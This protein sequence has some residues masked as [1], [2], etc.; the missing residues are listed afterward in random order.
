MVI[1]LF[2]QSLLHSK[3]GTLSTGTWLHGFDR[4][5]ARYYVTIAEHGYT[6]HQPDARAFFPGYPLVVRAA[7]S[8][9][10]GLFSYEQTGCLVSF[11]AFVLATALLYRLVF[12]RFGLRAALV[13]SA[14]FCWFPT[15][16]FFLAPYSEAFFALEILTVA[17]LVDRRRWWWAAVVVGYASATSPEALVLVVAL[18]AAALAAHRG[19]WRSI[20]YGLVGS[21]GMAAYV[22]YLGLRF[23]KPLDFIDVES[24]FHRVAIAPFVGV[25]EN[26]GAIPH[27]LIVHGSRFTVL[28]N[29]T[30]AALSTNIAWMWIVDDVAMLLAVAA[31]IKLVVLAV[32]R[33]REPPLGRNPGVPTFWIVVLAGIVL[34][35]SSTVLRSKGSPVSTE[36]AARLVSVA[37]PLYPGLY[38]LASRRQTVIIVGLAFSIT[39]ACLTQILFNL[40]YWVT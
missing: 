30:A 27:A 5:D 10:A 23:K 37:F 21:L 35:V 6:T 36:S 22:L 19:L 20:G 26:I 25:I 34:I 40:G 18:A 38:L 7:H 33:G 15:S 11:I 2:P 32:R 29:L 4:W 3:L 13:S 24:N 31:L 14:L 9:T 17:T 16:V 28:P 1:V 39:A 12:E 8:L